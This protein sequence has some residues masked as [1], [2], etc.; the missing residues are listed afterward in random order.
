MFPGGWPVGC[1]SGCGIIP[2]ASGARRLGE[3]FIIALQSYLTWEFP[4][5]VLLALYLFNSYI[6]FGNHPV[7]NYVDAVGQKLLSPLKKIP[8][9]LGKADFT[10]VVGIALVFLIAEFAGRGLRFSTR[11]CLIEWR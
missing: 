3:S 4:L 8:L 6:Y 7:W 5:A 11:D 1:W 10:S 9:S 2:P